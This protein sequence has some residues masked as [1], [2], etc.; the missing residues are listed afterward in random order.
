VSV[1]ALRIS[2]CLCLAAA[3]AAL[4]LIGGW[5]FFDHDE[6]EHLHSAWYVLTGARP[7]LDFF[8]H[9]HPLLWYLA[10]PL[11]LLSGQQPEALL[12][13]RS[14]MLANTGLILYLT[15]LLGRRLWG[16]LAGALAALSLM[17]LDLFV[18]KA[19]EFRPDGPMTLFLLAAALSLFSYLER[20]RLSRAAWM[21]L[22]LGAALL[23]LQKAVFGICLFGLIAAVE[24]GRGR[25]DWREAILALA[26]GLA[27]LAPG[28]I[29]LAAS[30]GFGDYW[31]FNW[32]LNLHWLYHFPAHHAIRESVEENLL[33]YLA[34]VAG[35]CLLAFDK[36][37]RDR[38]LLWLAVLGGGLY[39]SAFLVRLPHRQYFLPALPFL[40]VLA[41]AGWSRLAG[42]LN[43]W[44][45]VV[46]L[47]PVTLLIFSPLRAA[48]LQALDG[49]QTDQRAKMAYVLENA[50]PGEVVYDGDIQFNIFRG[51]VDFFWY[52][53]KP[54]AGLET[55]QRLRPYDYDPYR[56]I[57]AKKPQV[58]SSFQLDLDNPALA[59]YRTS[60]L[61]PDLWLRGGNGD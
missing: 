24:A 5:R 37:T 61:Y 41:G 3:A 58:I 16:S 4:V 31:F 36:K 23:F 43:N 9:H 22:F 59:G 52:S 34:A 33:F 57:A 10:A 27:V 46:W 40:A 19:I 51:D 49:R 25:I 47:I 50:R 14:L 54:G 56:L 60:P 20:P 8:Q 11:I 53:L 42:T 48:V 1:R 44:P 32:T 13:A 15:Y 30:G 7:Y 55:Y 26:A 29:C 38:R 45:R 28:A 39:L 17:S 6:M 21:G 18:Q 2:L 12:S 35:F